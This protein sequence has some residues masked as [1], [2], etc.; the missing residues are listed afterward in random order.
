MDWYIWAIYLLLIFFFLIL[1]GVA[2]PFSLGI[3]SFIIAIAGG[4]MDARMFLSVIMGYL[5]DSPSILA[6]PLF[7]LTGAIISNTGLSNRLLNG[8]N[9][10]VG[11]IR[12]G[13][14]IVNIL[15]SFLFGGVSGS[16]IS[17]VS[18]IGSVLIPG[19]KERGYDSD[20]SVVVTAVSATL[21]PVV[22]PSVTMIVLGTLTR[23]SV[24]ALFVAGYIPGLLVMVALC[25]LSTFYSIKNNY[26]R[27]IGIPIKK[28]LIEIFRAMPIFFLVALIMFG[29]I[30]GIFT[31]TE[32]GAMGAVFAIVIGFLTRDLNL[33]Q[34]I[35]A[36]K[37]AICVTGIAAFGL[38]F[39]APFAYL[40]TILRIPEHVSKFMT[41]I[42]QSPVVFLILCLLLFIILGCFINPTAILMMTMPILYPV[43]VEMGVHTLHF[44]IITVMALALGPITPPVGAPLYIAADLGGI[45][46]E[47]TIPLLSV[48]IAVVVFVILILIFFPKIVL[49][50][51]NIV[52]LIR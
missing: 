9:A 33:K 35:N 34:L 18:S 39:V 41:N 28:R 10:L 14:S 37:E 26:P 7:V 27:E 19:M 3:S 24:S 11:S 50:L 36:V 12:G 17:D 21:G 25:M 6:I 40:I 22:P 43:A 45:S 8:A 30:F 16:V 52:G 29:I 2:I 31:A 44:G 23:T 48:F 5:P 47:K 46:I 1:L 42:S 38:S 15:A 13:L 51:P 4:F 32:A 20:F 49:W